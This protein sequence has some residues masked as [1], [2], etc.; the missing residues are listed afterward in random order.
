MSKKKTTVYEDQEEKRRKHRQNFERHLVPC[1][2]CGEQV[3]D[4]M[5]K[6]PKC[7]G[8]LVPKGYRPMNEKTMKIVKGVLYTVCIAAAI[9]IVVV[10]MMNR[11]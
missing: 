2:H 11:G 6:C 8:E 7:G 3:L 4:H 10:I 9:V 5:T 1:P